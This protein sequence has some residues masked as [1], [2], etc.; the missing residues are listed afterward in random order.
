[1]LVFFLFEK[2]NTF[3]HLLRNAFG[4]LAIF[5]AERLII[6]IGAASPTLTS[7]AIGTG[8]ARVDGYFLHATGKFLLQYRVVIKV[9]VGGK[10]CGKNRVQDFKI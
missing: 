7:I 3:L 4:R 6:A 10:R 9:S 8:K 5:G 2:L 1:M